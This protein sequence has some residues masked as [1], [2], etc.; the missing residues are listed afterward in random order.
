MPKALSDGLLAGGVGIRWTG[1]LLA[2]PALVPLAILLL[3]PFAVLAID[4][5]WPP[6]AWFAQ[7]RE[8]LT[9]QNWFQRTAAYLA[10]PLQTVVINTE[11]P[12]VSQM[13]M[14]VAHR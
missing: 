6:T 9:G 3:L 8:S 7:W 2:A 4:R 14:T 12:I 5:W 13:E 11:S 1:V 10:I